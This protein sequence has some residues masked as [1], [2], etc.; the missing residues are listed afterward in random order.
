MDPTDIKGQNTIPTILENQGN[1]KFVYDL[2]SRLLK[3]RVIFVT[4]PIESSVSKLIIAQLLYL[5]QEDP[6]TDIKLYINSPGGS[7]SAGLAIYDTM[8]HISAEVS[9]IGVGTAASMGSLLLSSGQKGKRYALPNT[10][11]L[12]HQPLVE[13]GISG[14]A[15]DI[16]IQTQHLL[17]IK[18]KT[19]K[20]L[21]KNTGQT[22]DKIKKDSDRDNWMTAKEAKQ[23][24]LI[25]KIVE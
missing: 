4:G 1:E 12:I 15:S 8:N 13:G 5:D 16:E 17:K 25:D 11:V 9:T 24:G 2:Y 19:E 14:Q 3:D 23:Y 22:Q 20:I 21:A 18:D 6:H 7:I 10:E